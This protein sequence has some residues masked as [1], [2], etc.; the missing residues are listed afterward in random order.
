MGQGGGGAQTFGPGTASL[1][2]AVLGAEGTNSTPGEPALWGTEQDR[3]APA[4]ARVQDGG[5]W[6]VTTVP[7]QA[8]VGGVPAPFWSLLTSKLQRPHDKRS[9]QNLT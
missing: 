4:E 6:N 7:R 8:G 2:S 9:L 1:H 3:D 5:R